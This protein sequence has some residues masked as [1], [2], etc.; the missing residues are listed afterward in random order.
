MTCWES[1][2]ASIIEDYVRGTEQFCFILKL[3]MSI[4]LL[5]LRNICKYINSVRLAS[6][7][8]LRVHDRLKDMDSR[9]GSV[10]DEYQFFGRMN[11]RIYSLP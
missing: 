11:I 2:N 3:F 10:W 5:K 9:C 6:K 4:A 8:K 1:R 7:Q